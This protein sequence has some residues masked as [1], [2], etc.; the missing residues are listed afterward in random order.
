MSLTYL[1]VAGPRGILRKARQPQC[2]SLEVALVVVT[3][4]ADGYL[5]IKVENLS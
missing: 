1:F 3:I 5:N 2:S 4:V